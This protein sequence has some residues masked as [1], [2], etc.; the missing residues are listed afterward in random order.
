MKTRVVHCKEEPCDVY[1]GRKNGTQEHY[2]N[3]FP[4][5]RYC[6][7]EMSINNFRMWIKGIDFQDILPYRRKWIL[8]NL[9]K[10]RGKTLGCWCHP[11]KCHGDV[12]IELLEEKK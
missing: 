5:S 1:I 7:R 6:D 9:G 4:I 11:E 2:G 10:L 3:P 12:Y 8:D